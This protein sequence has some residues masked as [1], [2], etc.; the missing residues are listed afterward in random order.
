MDTYNNFLRRAALKVA[1]TL[2]TSEKQKLLCQ[3]LNKYYP[4][5]ELQEIIKNFSS[6]LEEDDNI[7]SYTDY[8]ELLG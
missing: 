1:L 6:D 3:I 5:E 8:K 2:E 4:E 7:E